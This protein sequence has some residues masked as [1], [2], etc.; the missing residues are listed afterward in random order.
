MARLASPRVFL[1]R[2]RA[3]RGGQPHSPAVRGAQ[4]HSLR[5]NV[6]ITL[7]SV[8][9]VSGISPPHA[10][11]FFPEY[12]LLHLCA[13]AE[14]GW[15]PGS[16]AVTVTVCVL[17]PAHLAEARWADWLLLVFQEFLCSSPFVPPCSTAHGGRVAETKDQEMGASRLSEITVRNSNEELSCCLTWLFTWPPWW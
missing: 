2:K 5:G 16:L 17:C 1:L 3:Q 7:K 10:F 9:V 6:G 4:R 14:P 11:F 8:C 12:R 15:R 13:K